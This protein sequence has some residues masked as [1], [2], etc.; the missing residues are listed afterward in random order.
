MISVPSPNWSS[1]EG[2]AVSMVIVHGTGSMSTSGVLSW[3]CDERSKVSY[4]Y[5]IGRDGNLYRCV[6]EKAKAW[7]A[8]RSKW[9]GREIGNSVNP[10]SIGIGLTSDGSEPYTD[11]QYWTLADLLGDIMTRYRIPP[12]DV[13]GHAEV[14]PGRKVDPYDVFDWRRV[15]GEVGER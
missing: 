14:S 1:R 4:H 10:I 11:A 7:H 9:H 12:C 3:I 2:H 6:L 8:G 13:R 5:L 15:L